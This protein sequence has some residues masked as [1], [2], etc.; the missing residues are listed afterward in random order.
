[1]LRTVDD[2]I[3][4]VTLQW[5][6]E[7][8]REN[9]NPLDVQRI[10]RIPVSSNLEDDLVAWHLTKTNTFLVRS[11]Y[12]SEWNHLN[13]QRLNRVDHQGVSTTNPV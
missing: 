1:M 4:P 8:L 11:A 6:E 10:L 7:L 9:L 12:Y 2:L 3:N 5:D 13:G